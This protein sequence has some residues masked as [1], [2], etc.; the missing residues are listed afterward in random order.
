MAATPFL[1]RLTDCL[2]RRE[3]QQ[4]DD[5]DGPELSPE[6]SAIVVGYG[7]FGQ[8]VAQMMQAKG[9]GGHDHRQEAEQIELSSEFGTKVY[10]GDGLRID[11]LRTAGAETAKVI[12]FCNDNEGGEISREARSQAVL[13]AFPQASVM[14]R[15]FDRVHLIELAG[16][17]SSCPARAVRKRGG[18]GQ[19]GAAGRA[20]SMGRDRASRARIS[21]RAIANGSNG[22]ARRVT[23]APG[24]SARSA[25]NGRFPK[26]RARPRLAGAAPAD[27]SSSASNDRIDHVLVRAVAAFHVDVRFL[28]GRP[29]L[30]GQALERRLGIAVAELRARV[31]ARRS[32]G[33]DVD[34]RVEPDGDRAL[35]EQLARARVD[36]G[37]AAGGDDPHLALDQAR[38][39][40]PLAVAEILLA[41]AF[42][43]FG[44]GK[45]G[46]RPRSP[47]SLSTNGSPSRLARRRPT[48]DFPTPISPTSTTG[49][50]RR[51]AKSV[52]VKGYT[53][54]LRA[55]QKRGHVHDCVVLIVL[56][57]VIIGG[58][59]LPVDAAQAAADPHDRGR[60]AAGGQCALSRY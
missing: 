11:L 17:T 25:P 12:A 19:G 48:V 21:A 38:D 47:Q 40:P 22:R 32:L 58:L 29:A 3:V 51:F 53:A 28:V 41:K 55:R 20:G 31:A 50:S 36:E 16:S 30:L 43:H 14:V 46:R 54:A 7:R 6:T 37:A 1:M 8:T 57:L 33:E 39:Q 26:R 34:R 18:D 52:T 44:G 2:E 49:R 42:E 45:A 9:I 27:K 56:V 10:Y 60:G 35:V 4:R 24:W 5:L 23:S 13:K 15:A 59:Y